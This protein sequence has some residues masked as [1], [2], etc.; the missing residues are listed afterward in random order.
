MQAGRQQDVND[1]AVGTGQL[2]NGAE[3]VR[4]REPSCRLGRPPSRDIADGMQRH[5]WQ[6]RKRFG[7][8]IEYVAGAEQ[9]DL[10]GG[11]Q[12]SIP[13]WKGRRFPAARE[14]LWPLQPEPT[15]ICL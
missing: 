2:R 12:T 15:C 5:T 6:G 7:M 10:L 1:V 13:V 8:R 3:H 11:C 14:R 9:S 4:Y